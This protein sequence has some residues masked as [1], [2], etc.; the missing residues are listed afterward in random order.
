VI[1]DFCGYLGQVKTV[2]TNNIAEV[3]DKVLGAAWGPQLERMNAGIYFPLFLVLVSPVRRYAIFYLPAD[4][5]EPAM[6]LARTPL[7]DKAKRAGWQGFIYDLAASR[8]R[9]VK[10]K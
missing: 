9:L 6:F 4:V 5:Q 1:C 3:P 10:L 8:D 2:T 7:S